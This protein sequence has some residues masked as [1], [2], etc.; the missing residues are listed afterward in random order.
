MDG[1]HNGCAPRPFLRAAV[2]IAA[3]LSLLASLALGVAVG[4]NEDGFLLTVSA[5]VGLGLWHV[6]LLGRAPR[7]SR[8]LQDAAA[9]TLLLIVRS[10]AYQIGNCRRHGSTS[11]G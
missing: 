11:F 5:L 10:E 9:I 6:T 4:V 8:L 2:G 7:L 3:T 1:A